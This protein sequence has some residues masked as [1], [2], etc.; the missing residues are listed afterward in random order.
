[1][2]DGA[3]ARCGMLRDA[4]LNVDRPACHKPAGL[5]LEAPLDAVTAMPRTMRG[6]PSPRGRF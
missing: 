1:M 5:L 6:R 3:P 4:F 2:L